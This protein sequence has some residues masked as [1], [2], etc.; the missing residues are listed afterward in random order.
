MSEAT[1]IPPHVK[2]LPWGGLAFVGLLLVVAV[3]YVAWAAFRNQSPPAKPTT[4]VAAEARWYLRSNNVQ[5]LSEPLA[6]LL[7]LPE[8]SLVKSQQH[9]LLNQAA[10]DFDLLDHQQRHWQLQQLLAKGPVVVI[11]YYGYHCN[12]C[13]GQL[14]AVHDDM[15]RF[16][17]LGAQV[18]AISADPPAMTEQRFKQYGVF[19]FPVLSDPGNKVAQAYGVFM[20]ATAGKR[21]DLQ[22]GTF[23]VGRDGR[24]TWCQVGDEPFT[25]N[26]MLLYELARVEGRLKVTR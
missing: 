1:P 3:S 19:A 9:P 12:H 15:E 4:D 5:P 2:R 18:V 6:K 21:E 8:D 14:F 24:V 20:P 23:V 13:V 7:A 10:P 25:N 16:K 17:E 26:R 11:F 22:H